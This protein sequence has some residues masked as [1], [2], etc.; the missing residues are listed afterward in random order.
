MTN[1]NSKETI[2]YIGPMSFPDGGAGPRRIL[3]NALSLIEA[4]YNVIV[5]SGQMPEGDPDKV[6][7]FCGVG[8]Y[9]VGERTAED[10]PVLIKHLIYSRMGRK[11]VAW[12]KTLNPKPV[13]V[14][15]FGG[16]IPYLSNL[17]PWCRREGIPVIFEACEWYDPT[18]MPGG[19]FSP[20]RINFEITMR[21]YVP[22]LRNVL[23]ISSYLENHYKNLGCE[24]VCIPP[25]VDPSHFNFSERLPQDNIISLSYSGSPGNKDL[26]DNYLEALL[27]LDPSGRR[28]RFNVAGLT[29]KQILDYPA[30][31]SRKIK[32]L[33]EMIKAAGRV[34]HSDSVKLTGDSDFSLLLRYDRRYSKAGFPTKV[35]ESMIIGTPVICNLTSDLSRYITDGE[36]G[37][38]CKDH[39]VSGLV[40]ALTR[41]SA[42]KPEDLLKMR[43]NVR[44]IA[45]SS[46]NYRA[47]VPVLKDF[48]ERARKL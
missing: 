10:K 32:S 45:E 40:E 35:V 6:T 23:A 2:A 17:M 22:R 29:D 21:M 47:F 13:A 44:R 39:Q 34:S 28:F 7:D 27:Q 8:V 37:I 48:I 18:N 26:F 42:M 31:K 36:S 14:I 30:M 15:L 16:D 4:G 5:G 46:F 43:R 38:V 24:T 12:L 9:S 25:T 11:T 20:Y 33:P 19:R 3:G 1:S 41:A